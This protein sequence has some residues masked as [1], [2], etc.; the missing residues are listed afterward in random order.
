MPEDQNEQPESKENLLD[1]SDQDI[2]NMNGKEL[3]EL[4]RK[5][6]KLENNDKQSDKTKN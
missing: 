4:T 1:I 5:I 2:Q 3:D 6:D